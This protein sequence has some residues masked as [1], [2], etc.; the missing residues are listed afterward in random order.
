MKRKPQVSRAAVA[1]VA[2]TLL[3]SGCA[4]SNSQSSGDGES[5]PVAVC[6]LA[7]YT[8]EFGSYGESLTADVVFP[9]EEVINE[10]PPLGREWKL[11]HE[12]LGTV[13]EAQAARTCLDRH[14]ADILVSIAHGYRTYRDLMMQ[15]WEEQDSPLGPTVHGGAIPGNLGGK[16]E[17]PI[18]RA[19]GLDETLGMTGALYAEEI[20]AESVVIFATNVE[21]FQLAADAAE[22]TAEHLGIEVLGR[23][24]A[25]AE[26]PSYVAEARKIADLKPD[27]VIMQAG[28]VESATLIKQA[29]EA[30]ISLEW[31]GE[32][33]WVQPEFM[34]TLGTGPLKAQQGVGFAAFSYNEDS[35]AWDF[36]SEKWKNTPGYGDKFGPPSDAYHY[37]TYDLMVQ[38]ALA[39]EAGGSYKASDWAPAMHE[40]GEAPGTKCYTYE[41]CLE[42]VR[43][44]EEIDYDGVT[45]TGEYT[46]GGVNQIVQAYTPF[47]ENGEPGEPVVIDPQRALEVVQAIATEAECDPEDPP[48]TCEW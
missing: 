19:Q 40:V 7:Y 41:E 31:I 39:V 46:E 44:G 38:T 3:A 28:S 15:R 34:K 17:E 6:E 2:T 5:G 27:A 9:V 32:T 29:T 12:D 8:G 35:P 24:D 1:L 23:I 13:G 42:L 47:T 45:G 25:A 30:G 14:D 20:G 4:T 37:S 10:D 48:N 21:G 22:K 11:Y 18:F 36:F 43:G 16:A 33:G 26:Q